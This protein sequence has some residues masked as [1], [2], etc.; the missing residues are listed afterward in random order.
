MFLDSDDYLKERCLEEVISKSRKHNVDITRFKFTYLYKNGRQKV[1]K[2]HFPS[3]RVIEKKD[4]PKLIYN[5]VLTGIKINSICKTLYKKEIIQDT[6][7][8]EDMITAEDLIFNMAVFTNAKNFL[9]LPY[10]YYYYYKSGKSLTGYGISLF[11]KYKYNYLLTTLILQY[12]KK[13]DMYK[14]RYIIKALLRPLYVTI[15]KIKRSVLKD[16]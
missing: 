14:I 6:L 13:W 12:L 15:S 3:G 5:K 7:F 9:Y 11:T 16:V 2:D 10:P 4:F 8:N 1:E